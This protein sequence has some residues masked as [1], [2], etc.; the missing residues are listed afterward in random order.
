[1]YPTDSLTQAA[2]PYK[3]P[4]TGHNLQSITEDP[5]DFKDIKYVT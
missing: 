4:R 3:Q 5:R 1:M 2:L